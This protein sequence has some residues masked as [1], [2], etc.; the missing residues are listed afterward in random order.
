MW[1]LIRKNICARMETRWTEVIQDLEIGVEWVSC[2]IVKELLVIRICCWWVINSSKLCSSWSFVMGL[3]TSGALLE[4]RE[5]IGVA[6]VREE[7]HWVR[8][9]GVHRVFQIWV[10]KI[11]N[12]IKYCLI[13]VIRV[14]AWWET[15]AWW[16]HAWLK[17]KLERGKRWGMK[18]QWENCG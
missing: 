1:R 12:C 5:R 9:L 15:G 17:E 2:W 11:R 6:S 3:G 18:L 10:I 16:V 7:V 8:S 13:W 14:H 4:R